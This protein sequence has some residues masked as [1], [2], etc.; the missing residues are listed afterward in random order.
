MVRAIPKKIP[1]DIVVIAC[2]ALQISVIHHADGTSV[3]RY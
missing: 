3:K 1:F 2:L